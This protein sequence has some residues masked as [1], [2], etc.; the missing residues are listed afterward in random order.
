MSNKSERRSLGK[1]IAGVT[2]PINRR[3]MK[4]G[5]NWL[6][7][8]GSDKKYKKCCL[9]EI[10]SITVLDGN[11]HVTKLPEHIKKMIDAH[12]KAEENAK[13]KLERGEKINE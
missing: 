10:D 2:M 11:A 1:R 12:R 8:C 13:V 4:W 7:L 9:A 6:C 5:R 3:R